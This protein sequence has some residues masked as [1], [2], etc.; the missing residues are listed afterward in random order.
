MEELKL[1]NYVVTPRYI[2]SDYRNGKLTL[3]ERNLFLWL[4]VCGSPYGIA[5]VEMEGLAKETFNNPVDKSYINKLLLS[6]KSKRYIWYSDRKGRRGS[7]DVH[8]GD[9]ILPNKSIKTLDSYF[10]DAVVRSGEYTESVTRT[11]VDEEL[12]SFSQKFTEQNTV[13][14][15]SSNIQSIKELLRGYDNDTEKEKENDNESSRSLSFK[16]RDFSVDGFIP[17]SHEEERCL[18]LATKLGDEG[19]GFY[20]GIYKQHGLGPLDRAWK[21]FKNADGFGKDHPPAFFNALVQQQL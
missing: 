10:G 2:A 21:E 7:F 3:P 17:L 4:R 14:K 16:K 12:A 20:Y 19:V 13:T 1:S 8:M 11:E 9:W 18:N 15:S 5:I 6:L